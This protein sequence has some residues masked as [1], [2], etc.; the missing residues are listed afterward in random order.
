MVSSTQGSRKNILVQELHILEE[1][2]AIGIKK[3][4]TKPGTSSSTQY[5]LWWLMLPLTFVVYFLQ[6]NL[7]EVINA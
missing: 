3:K 5:D 1:C 7:S 2:N 4:K 6:M